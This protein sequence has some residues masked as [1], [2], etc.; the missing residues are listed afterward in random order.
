MVRSL[1]T[2]TLNVCAKIQGSCFKYLGE[3]T[4]CEMRREAFQNLIGGCITSE[5]LI[6]IR[7]CSRS[8]MESVS[9][10]FSS[11]Q[12]KLTNNLKIFK[13]PVELIFLCHAYTFESTFFY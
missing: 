13:G 9:E 2:G 4:N 8:M 5:S 7:S 1:E 11:E 10:R 12:S 6:T 3:E